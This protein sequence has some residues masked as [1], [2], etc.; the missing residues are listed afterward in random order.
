M[1]DHKQT[2][3][4]TPCLVTT[5]SVIEQRTESAYDALME[6]MERL[7]E[8]ATASAYEESTPS[9]TNQV[10]YFALLA[11]QAGVPVYDAAEFIIVRQCTWQ[12]IKQLLKLYAYLKKHGTRFVEV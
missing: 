12:Q 8:V 5:T 7:W 9:I 6:Q 4:A 1:T 10:H 2:N 11:W 3:T